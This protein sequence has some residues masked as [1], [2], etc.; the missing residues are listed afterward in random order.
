MSKNRSSASFGPT[1]LAAAG[2]ALR[3]RTENQSRVK[4]NNPDRVMKKP[5]TAK[6]RKEGKAA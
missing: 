1:S 5:G 6:K 4:A 3:W 2:A